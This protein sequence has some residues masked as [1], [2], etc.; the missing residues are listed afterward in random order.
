MLKDEDVLSSIPRITPQWVAGFFDGEGSVH[1]QDCRGS[2]QVRVS[3]SQKDPKI[4]ALISL[5]YNAGSL[6]FARG[7]GRFSNGVHSLIFNGGNAVGFLKD[8]E[9]YCVVKRRLVE[10]ALEM[11]EMVGRHQTGEVKARKVA[12]RQE[13]KELN[14]LRRGAV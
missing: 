2:I 6:L 5:K 8:I 12:L 11:A 13:T 7:I 1:T 4:L 14:N 9:P 3:I 10:K